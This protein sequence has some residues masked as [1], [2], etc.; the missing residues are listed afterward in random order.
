MSSRFRNYLVSTHVEEKKAR[1]LL[2]SHRSARNKPQ[3]GSILLSNMVNMS[4]IK[5]TFKGRKVG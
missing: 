2:S 5:N 1:T 3:K 4:K